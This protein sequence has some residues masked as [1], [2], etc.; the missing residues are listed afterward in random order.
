[1]K[2]VV[3]ALLLLSLAACGGGGNQNQGGGIP[4]EVVDQSCALR[5]QFAADDGGCQAAT[6]GSLRANRPG[7]SRTNCRAAA[8][9]RAVRMSLTLS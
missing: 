9:S 4:N 3:V 7:C 2:T 6:G 8:R 1:M 5:F